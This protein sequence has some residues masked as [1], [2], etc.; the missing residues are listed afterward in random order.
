MNPGD[1][2][3][4]RDANRPLEPSENPNSAPAFPSP[5][6]PSSNDSNDGKER[7][8]ESHQP[9]SEKVIESDFREEHP[10]VEYVKQNKETIGTYLVLLIGIL[11][12]IFNVFLLGS[13]MIGLI[14]GFHFSHEIVFYLRNLTLIFSG[15]DQLRYI[16]LTA[17]VVALFIAIPGIFIGALVAAV[18]RQGILGNREM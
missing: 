6:S 3:P 1:Q 7:D 10:Y 5:P 2:Y 16:V 15:Q 13:L 12:L 18:F 8:A 14:A 17:V 11:F 4:E 9:K